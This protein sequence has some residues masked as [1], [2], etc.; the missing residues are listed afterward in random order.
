MTLRRLTYWITILAIFAMAA[1]ISVDSDTWWHLRAGQWMVEKRTLLT[2]D[3]FSYT[4]FGESWLYPG[5]LFEVPM[6]WI[7]KTFGAGGLNLM[8][9]LMVTLAFIFV[10]TVLSGD[11]FV[12][13]FALIFA[14]AAAGVYWSARPHLVTLLFTAIFLKILEDHRWQYNLAQRKRLFWLPGLMI[15]WVNSHGGFILGFIL[16]GVYALDG[17]LAW[18][19]KKT[20]SAR[21]WELLLN[22]GLM[23]VGVCLN[24][25]GAHMLLYPFHTVGIRTLQNYIQEW[26]SP[27][28][29]DLA[30]QPFAWLLLVLVGMLGLSKNRIALTDFLL[31]TGLAYMSLLAGRNIAI[32]ALVAPVVIT[33]H[34]APIVTEWVANRMKQ[35]ASNEINI[36]ART[37][38]NWL[39]FSLVLLAVGLKV[40][41]VLPASANERYFRE[42]LP[43]AAVEYLKGHNYAGNLFNAYDWGGY[44]LWSLP[45]YP[46][47]IDGRTDLYNDEIINQWLQVVRAEPGWQETL[48]SWNIR[49][50]LIEPDRPV[51]LLLPQYGWK[52]VFQD[53]H[54]VIFAK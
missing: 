12:R 35:P 16:W 40:A 18:A 17:I 4:R 26:Q 11:T 7:F 44:L 50:I 49:L 30:V 3:P 27:N 22:G 36:S 41:I 24:P 34:A 37:R 5:W 38:I 2:T 42:S 25:S 51:V 46:V 21:V 6:Y 1:R 33:R 14:A 47:F 31:C 52:N 23:V 53:N 8:T 32:F 43:V 45:E 13:S 15:L 10:W 20:E 29:H 19:L 54:A 9:A 48:E 28:F 39:I